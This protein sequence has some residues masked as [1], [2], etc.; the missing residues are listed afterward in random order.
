MTRDR[1]TPGQLAL[2]TATTTPL[3]APGRR[4]AVTTETGHWHGTVTDHCTFRGAPRARIDAD[5]GQGVL[6]AILRPG[7]HLRP[8]A[9]GEHCPDCDRPDPGEPAY[10]RI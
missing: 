6:C 5:P 9:K 8:T 1:S 10:S 2:D 7:P 3:P 4:V